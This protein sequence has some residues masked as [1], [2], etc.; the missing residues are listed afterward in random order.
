MHMYRPHKVSCPVWLVCEVTKGN[1]Y[2]VWMLTS[3]GQ[4][5]LWAVPKSARSVVSHFLAAIREWERM[6]W[7]KLVPEPLHGFWLLGLRASTDSSAAVQPGFRELFEEELWEDSAEAIP[8]HS[9]AALNVGNCPCSLSG[10]H[11]VH[12]GAQPLN[13]LIWTWPAGQHCLAWPYACLSI[14]GLACRPAWLTVPSPALPSLFRFCGT[15]PSGHCPAAL[16]LAHHAGRTA[17]CSFSLRAQYEF[18]CCWNKE[19][20]WKG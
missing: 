14:S 13:S 16:G 1:N 11:C 15:C 2:T 5:T 3:V 10:V 8:L 7:R 4:V 9:G 12:V 20:I 17:S 6:N 19:T 18:D